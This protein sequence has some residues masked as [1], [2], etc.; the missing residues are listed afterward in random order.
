MTDPHLPTT[1]G[2]PR[3]TSQLRAAEALAEGYAGKLRYVFGTQTGWHFW[4]GMRWQ[5][6]GTNHT[7]RALHK[8]AETLAKL[9]VAGIEPVSLVNELSR[10]AG[11]RG[12]LEM[13]QYLDE[14]ATDLAQ[15]D[16][17]PYLLNCRNG[18]LDLKTLT[19]REHDPADMLTQVTACDYDPTATSPL[20]DQFLDTALPD[21]EVREYLQ[22]MIGYSL[23]GEVIHH[24]FPILI[25]EGGNG[26]GTFYEVVMH[27]L[28]DYAAPFDSALLIQ[29]RTDFRSA[30][31]PAPALL[32]LKG[33]R[34][35]VTSETDEGAKL[36]T[37]KMKFY[38]GGDTITAR[39]MY[40]RTDTV[41][42][43]SHTMFMVTNYEPML[44]SEDAAA[45]QR[46]TTIP[47]DVKIRGTDLEI[48][49]FT[50]QLKQAAPAVLAWAVEGLRM[51]YE[52][53]LDAPAKVRARTNEYHAKTDS[54]A[55]YISARLSPVDDPKAKVPRTQVWDD[56][57]RW[58][59]AEGAEVGRQSDFYTKVAKHYDM[60]KTSGTWVFRGVELAKDD[61]DVEIDP[62]VFDDPAVVEFRS[63]SSTTPT[64]ETEVSS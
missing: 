47:F 26:K 45:W 16:A 10:S 35:V 33:K 46:I 32:G 58:A 56:W 5:P 7:H 59:K 61:L 11:R 57:L 2:K 6:D 31:A 22:R 42:T 34:F 50:S 43:P 54:I 29:T 3:S 17:K 53:G 12:A 62:S 37:A 38:T 9:A 14:F 49:G 30:N 18:T 19:L 25:G 36:A 51:Y 24:V 8:T 28:G 64:T 55:T 23:I 1:D 21:V 41:F 40:A 63:S 52:R 60:A 27:T 15:M 48:P 20:W 44:S 13:A 39:A 4:D